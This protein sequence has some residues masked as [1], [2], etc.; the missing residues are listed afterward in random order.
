MS[1]LTPRLRNFLFGVRSALTTRKHVVG[2][3]SSDLA[4]LPSWHR[5][6]AILIIWTR[7]PTEAAPKCKSPVIR[8]SV[9]IRLHHI[10]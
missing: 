8:G 3:S 7:P 1:R 6:C 2:S 4:S 10:G 5:V 9:R